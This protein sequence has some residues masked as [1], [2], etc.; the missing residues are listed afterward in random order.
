MVNHSIMNIIH[1]CKSNIVAAAPVSEETLQFFNSF[2]IPLLDLY[3]QSEGTG[4][5]TTN[6]HLHQ[7]WKLYTSGK[8]LPGIECKTD[9]NTNEL[10]YRGRQV[11]MGYLK[12][13]HETESTITDDGWIHT[14][15]QATIDQ[16]GFVTITG[17][18]K[19]LIVTA[20]GENISPVPIENK[21]LENCPILANCVVIGD[22]R[23]F[24]SCLLT[25]K[26]IFDPL[27]GQPTNRLTPTCIN[28]LAKH[29]IQ[30]KTVEEA[31]QNPLLS[32]L[33][34]EGIEQYNKVAVS[35]AQNVRKWILLD[36]DLSLATGELTATL[37]LRRGVVQLNFKEKINQ[38]YE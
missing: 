16:D 22:K 9:E 32:T 5:V 25:L 20:G 35:R 8:P 27:T 2:D 34:N 12:M 1:S 18:L 37:K 29:G 31:K 38:L 23:K 30:A 6:S 7:D 14:G 10:L 36:R 11:M 24:L 3:G 21:I 26:T 13:E 4:P 28:E 15:D 19:E 17:R 33:I